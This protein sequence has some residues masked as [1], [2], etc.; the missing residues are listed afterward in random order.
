MEH[1]LKNRA[2]DLI[3]RMIL[4]YLIA[5]TVSYLTLPS[6]WQAL[7]KVA[8]LSVLAPARILIMTA[9]LTFF[10]SLLG[11]FVMTGSSE[12]VLIALS[13]AGLAAAVMI[14][15]PFSYALLAVCLLIEGILILYAVHAWN[16]TEVQAIPLP[17]APWHRTCLILLTLFFTAIVSLWGISRVIGF[18]TPTYDFGIFAQMFHSMKSNG[19]PVTTLERDGLLSHFHVHV[20]PIY[21]LML[22]LYTLIPH[23]ATL[24]VM[25]AAVL[26]SAVV[27]LWL[28][29]KHHGLSG[30]QR[31][32]L[33][34]A[35]LFYPALA[36]GAA[37]DLHENCFL[38]PLLLWL[39]LGIDRRSLPLTLLTAVLTLAV[40][41]DAAVYVAIIALWMMIR[42][43]LHA[44]HREVIWGTLLF[45]LSLGYFLLT[46]NYL[47]TVG[48]GVMSNRYQNLMAESNDSLFSVVVFVLSHP[49]KALFECVDPEKL[50]YVGLTLA[51]L[52]GL[53]LLTRRYE[54][55]L[56]LIPYVL[57]NLMPDYVYQ[58][59][60]FFQYSF[61]SLACLFYL[62][63][64]NLADL[65]PR[66]RF[67]ALFSVMAVCAILFSTH[68]LPRTQ[69]YLSRYLENR[70]ECAQ[71][72]EVLDT[73]PPDASVTAGTFMTTYLS[74]RE[75]L[76]DLGY[77]T[78]EHLLSSAYVVIDLNHEGELTH[79][80]TG[81]RKNGYARLL[82]LLYSNGYE[83]YGSL[84]NRLIVFQKSHK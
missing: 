18:A 83:V 14:K 12:R 55:Y 81:N 66:L 20:S 24:Q 40:K 9:I 34:S 63:A 19:L 31:L 27:P 47:A 1:S 42:A 2:S 36:G 35:L 46:T 8:P 26:A 76:Y 80:A 54:R 45:A 48:D 75:V 39:F 68:I 84:E 4:S 79:Y 25:Q 16:G 69:D 61:G 3:R 58:H 73:I 60:I 7:D 77:A 49:T 22:P 74:S 62:T 32:L 28:L 52:L 13:F 21:Y 82:S 56:L 29:G 6:E 23:P 33:C 43:L 37:Y 59:N 78:R 44:D 57:V 38:A 72:R 70:E 51:P 41:E 11:H 53:P 65:R 67:P 71:I 5:V 50:S 15:N 10:L 17:A 64:V 30:C